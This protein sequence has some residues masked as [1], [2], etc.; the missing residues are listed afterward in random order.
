M[1][2]LGCRPWHRV[3]VAVVNLVDSNQVPPEHGVPVFVLVESLP[4]CTGEPVVMGCMVV[5]FDQGVDLLVQFVVDI[6][7]MLVVVE[8]SEVC[9]KH[10]SWV[11]L[12]CFGNSQN[13]VSVVLGDCW[14]SLVNGVKPS[15]GLDLAGVVSGAMEV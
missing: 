3:M 12:P 10:N 1:A 9:S 14:V 6:G 8:I 7:T 15:F 4:N 5:V 11:D 13:D 2:G